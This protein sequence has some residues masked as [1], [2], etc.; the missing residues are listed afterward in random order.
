MR[1]LLASKSATRRRMLEAA[2]VPFVTVDSDLDEEAIKADLAGATM[3]AAVLA[4]TLAEKKALSARGE[5]LI[6]GSDQTLE[7][8]DGSRLDKPRSREEALQQLRSLSGRSH[9]LHSAAAIAEG[10]R[11]VWRGRESVKLIVR[12]LSDDFLASYLEQE[13]EAIRWGVGGYRIEG[14]GVQLFQEIEGS[15]FAILGIPLLPLFAY[16][17]ER[18]ILQ[19]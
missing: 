14:P 2:G 15:H 10:G 16:L 11:I 13:W 3:T 1:L 8:D 7:L 4:D 5:G 6:L 12:P 19:S 9:W 18:G 17:R